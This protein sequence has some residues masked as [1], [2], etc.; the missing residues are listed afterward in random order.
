MKFTVAELKQTTREIQT[1]KQAVAQ[2]EQMHGCH[3]MARHKEPSLQ[4]YAR[5]S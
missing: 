2:F 1:P 3:G 5:E 4:H